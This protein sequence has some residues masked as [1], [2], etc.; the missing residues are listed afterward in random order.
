VSDQPNLLQVKRDVIA[1]GRRA[2]KDGLI[3]GTA[4]N[5]S[6]RVGDVMVITASGVDYDLMKTDEV[7]VVGVSDGALRSGTEPSSETRMH[8]ATYRACDAG[9]V[10][11]THSPFVVALSCVLDVLPA[12]HYAMAQLGGP[13]RV[14]PYARF[15][16]DDLASVAVEGLQDRTAVI[17]GNHGALAYAATLSEAY[18]RASTLEWLA[19]AY[20]RASLVGSP[21]LLDERQLNDVLAAQALRQ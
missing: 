12:V 20:W 17:L 21:K 14:A 19:T 5:F 11:H 3:T 1:S 15:G 8:L 2:I 18:Q 9:A 16:T 10:V 7:C 13:V 6:V 4:G